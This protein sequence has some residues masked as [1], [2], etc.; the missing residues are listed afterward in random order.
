MRMIHVEEG[1]A[2]P[3]GGHIMMARG[4]HHVMFLGLTRPLQDGDNVQ[5]TLEFEKAGDIA[6]TVPVDLQRKPDHGNMGHGS[7][8]HG[9]MHKQSD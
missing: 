7:M 4:G 3:A 2:L 6:V 5:L 1:F 8:G 9:T